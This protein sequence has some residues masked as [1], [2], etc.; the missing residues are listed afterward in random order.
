MIHARTSMTRTLSVCAFVA[1]VWVAASASL[2]AAQSE[3]D[4]ARKVQNPVAD[5]ISVP[6]Q[7]NFNFGVGPHDDL[8]YILNIQP[9]IPVHLSENW[10]L[11]TRT[12]VP[13]VYQPVL[14][15]GLDDEFGL[16]DTQFS[17]FLSPAKSQGLIW[18]AGP[19][20]QF[21][22]TTDKL[23]GTEKWAAGPT[24]VV[25][26]MDGHW[27]FGALANNIWSYAGD[28]DRPNVNQFLVQP[29]VNY[30]LNDGWYVTTSPV[31]TANWKAAA[32]DTWTVPLGGGVGKIFHL[33]KLP[34]NGQF[35][36]FYNV[37]KPEGAPDWQARIQFQFLFPR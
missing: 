25:L 2:C 34:M 6:F 15:P 18:G 1:A 36:T 12:I 13:L 29:F 32:A 16:S 8:Q 17:M 4:L 33:G 10:N 28:S 9:V 24:A 37:E 21:P 22:T 11:I 3:G 7:S 30:N 19:I 5:L 20:L 23:L 31:V 27:V 26:R 14:A 35:Q